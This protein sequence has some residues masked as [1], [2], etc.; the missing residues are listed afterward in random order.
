MLHAGF[1][2]LAYSSTLKM[3]ARCSTETS[4]EFST[5]LPRVT[6]ISQTVGL[7]MTTAAR[8]SWCLRK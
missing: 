6:G 2:F 7:Y 4:V 8:T 1:V 3:N 5:I